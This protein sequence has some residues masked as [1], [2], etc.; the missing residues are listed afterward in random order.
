MLSAN[1]ILKNITELPMILFIHGKL[2]KHNLSRKMLIEQT[3]KLH[4]MLAPTKTPKQSFISCRLLVSLG[5]IFKVVKS[6]ANTK[7]VW[8]LKSARMK[9]E[10]NPHKL[11]VSFFWFIRS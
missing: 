1:I 8:G 9:E 6:N 4:H 2:F 10:K 11:N 7:T 5:I 3:I